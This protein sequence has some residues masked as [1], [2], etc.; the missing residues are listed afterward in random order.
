M[1]SLVAT[2]ALA[3]FGCAPFVR[4]DVS[5]PDGGTP[6]F[7]VLDINGFLV[8]PGTPITISGN[9]VATSPKFYL[10]DTEGS[11]PDCW[12]GVFIADPGAVGQ[13]NNGVL[14]SALADMNKINGDPNLGGENRTNCPDPTTY[15]V[16]GAIPDGI[17][18]GDRLSVEGYFEPYC[19]YYDTSAGQCQFSL[20]PEVTPDPPQGF[21]EGSIQDL[22]AGAPIPPLVVEPGQISDLAPEAIQYAAELVQVQQVSVS[23][24]PLD[25]YGDVVLDQASLWLTAL[26]D[27][28]TITDAPGTAYCSVTGNLHFQA[29]GSSGHWELRPRTQSDLVLCPTTSDGGYDCSLCSGG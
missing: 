23:D 25:E 18:I 12:Y 29:F 17:Q 19:G 13:P 10:R 22:N 6:S 3:A 4:S 24:L 16:G 20:F 9:P 26:F 14:L 27:E 11:A 21:S 8:P 1:R 15:Q 2:L 28:V 7:S 5:T